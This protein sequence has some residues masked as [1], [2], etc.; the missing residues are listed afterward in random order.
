MK[1][2]LLSAI[3]L[4]FTGINRLSSQNVIFFDE[5]MLPTWQDF[6][7]WPDSSFGA[8]AVIY[9]RIHVFKEELDTAV[10]VKCNA[11]LYSD[12]SWTT[13]QNRHILEHE[14]YHFKISEIAVRK[15]LKELFEFEL[16]GMNMDLDWWLEDRLRNYRLY[17]SSQQVQYDS[18]TKHG[19]DVVMQKKEELRIDRE[20]YSM[21]KYSSKAILFKVDSSNTILSRKL[22]SIN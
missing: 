19:N 1:I 14:I 12:S 5:D 21:N 22:I 13:T 9:T 4:F 10:L 8:T 11:L 2:K 7:G 15:L 17:D 16:T 6:T 18:S 20:L 3:L